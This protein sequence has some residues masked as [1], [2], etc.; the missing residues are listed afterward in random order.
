MDYLL[1]AEENF[2]LIDYFAVCDFNQFSNHAPIEF[3]LIC[4][5][6]VQCSDNQ[7]NEKLYKWN[8]DYKESFLNDISR[9]VNTLEEVIM[10]KIDDN[11]CIDEIVTFYTEFLTSRGINTSKSLLTDHQNHSSV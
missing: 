4:E 11:A 9:D 2:K 6:N 3:N 7:R 5:T 10:S 1:T 8:N